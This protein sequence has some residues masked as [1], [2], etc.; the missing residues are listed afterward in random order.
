MRTDR[1]GEIKE[2][3]SFCPSLSHS[4]NDG[5]IRIPIKIANKDRWICHVVECKKTD[6][7]DSA[8]FPKGCPILSLVD[9]YGEIYFLIGSLVHGTV[10][11]DTFIRWIIDGEAHGGKY[12]YD[13]IKDG[14]ICESKEQLDFPLTDDFIH[15]LKCSLISDSIYGDY[16]KN[17]EIFI[18]KLIEKNK[19]FQ[20]S[21]EESFDIIHTL[22]E[23]IDEIQNK[24]E[25]SEENIKVY[26][27]DTDRWTGRIIEESLSLYILFQEKFNS[28]FWDCEVWGSWNNWTSASEL[29]HYK[30]ID[31]KNIWLIEFS[32][33]EDLP[34]LGKYYYKL[35]KNGEWI[36]PNE[37]DLREKDENGNWN[38]V[39]FIHS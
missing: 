5:F 15:I 9:N 19:K 22:Q 38:F 27:S 8:Q 28:I 34:K 23:K 3:K 35:K 31:D 29:L 26:K 37:N 12:M 17:L 11:H 6:Y 14:L 2:I 24:S 36:E 13:I 7:I 32:T 39:I 25:Y 20:G 21:I 33:K 18:K 30:S 10:A 1:Y 16:R 4:L